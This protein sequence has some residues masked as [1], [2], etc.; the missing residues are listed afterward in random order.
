MRVLFTADC[1]AIPG[2]LAG[3]DRT[4]EWVRCGEFIADYAAENEVDLVVVSGDVFDRPRPTPAEIQHVLEWLNM[5]ASSLSP[6][7]I[8]PGTQS[9]DGSGPDRLGPTALLAG[10]RLPN[11]LVVT[12]PGVHSVHHKP[13]DTPIWLACLPG[14]SKSWLANLDEVKG[15]PP[16]EQHR[17]MA[18]RLAD[19]I[20]G[21]AAELA[22]ARGPKLLIG[23][24]SVDGCVASSD[25]SIRMTSEPV[26]ARGDLP[27]VF[28]AACFGHIHR[29]QVLQEQGPWIGYSGSWLRQNWGEEKDD[30]GFWV[31]DF[32]HSTG[33]LTAAEFVRLPAAELLTIEADVRSAT[34]P[35]SEVLNHLTFDQRLRGSIVHIRVTATEEQTRLID[36]KAVQAEAEACGVLHYAGLVVETERVARARV[37]GV[38][39]ELDPLRAVELYID[40]AATDLADDKA[41]L[42]ERARSLLKEVT[43]G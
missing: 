27:D 39:Q 5:T 25:E 37:E 43:A 9:H 38:T 14:F 10:L 36:P 20:R 2:A 32:D 3:L 33:T 4:D 18:A 11:V 26:L 15:L 24:L 13:T 6:V 29:P 12:E 8:M 34:D 31:L 1:H 42:L 41:D 17:V 7:V 30:R 21:F 23:H 22:G 19:I 40:E 16:V 35:L 28:D